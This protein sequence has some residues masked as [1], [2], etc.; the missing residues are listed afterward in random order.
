MNGGPSI[1]AVTPGERDKHDQKFDTLS[2]TMGYVSGEQARKFFLQSGLPSSVLAEI[3]SLADMNKDG[4]MDRL[5]FSIA[6]KLV[7]LKL[8][9]TPLPSALPTIMK[10]PPLPVLS[11][12]NPSSSMTNPAYGIGSLSNMSMMPGTNLSMLIPLSLATPG[13]SPLTPMTGLT[14]LVPMATG[15]S[16]L[17]ASTNTRPMGNVT[18]PNGTMG[19]LHPMPTGPLATGLPLSVSNY[20]SPLGMSSS[21]AGIYK[22]SSMLDLG[23]SSSA[24]SSPSV[25]SPMVAGPSDWAVPHASRLKYR[26]QFNGLDKQMTGHLTGQQVRGAMATTM[27]TQTQLASIW[28]LADV[29]KDGK[30]KAEEFILAMH[31]VDMA[32]T[33]LP[34]PL[35][36]P[37]ELVPPSQRGAVN[38]SSSSLYAA[39]TD[40]FDIEPPQK[41]K[42]NLSFED[43]FKANQERGNA[44]L[45]KRRLALQEAER[46]ELERRAQKE[47]EEREKRE[48]EAWEAEERRRKEE[49]RRLERQRELE[50]QKEEERQREIERKE[51][52]QRELE[53]QR[54]EEWE[55]RRR[56]ELQIKKQQEQDDI[57]R[58]KAKKRS[59]EM[60]L[61]AVGNKHRQISDRLRDI[62]NKKKLQRTELDL[63]SQ[64]KE[65]RQQDINSIHKQL[66]EFQRKLS[67]LTPEQKRL[68]EKLKNMTLNNLP[69]SSM[70]TMKV[71]VSEKKGTCMKLRDHLQTLEKETAA[72]LAEMDHYNKDMQYVGSEDSMLQAVF[73]LLACLRNLFYLLKELRESQRKQ[74][75]ALE[76]LRSVKEDKQR[77]LIRRKEQE[78]ERK[79]QEEE[80]RRREEEE[81]QR[82][83]K[84]EKE[85]QWQEKLK[86]DEEE[87]QRRLREEKE[88]KQREE[89]ERERQALIRAAKDQAER[90]F[91]AKEEAE[92]KRREEERRKREDEERKKKEEEERQRQVERQ[93]QEEERRKLEEERRK[94]EEERRKLEEERRKEEKRRKDEEE[95]KRLEAE[96]RDEECR[97]EREE[98][99]RR[100]KR[101][102]EAAVRDAE[103]R[104]K[105]D[106]E[107]RKRREE[108]DRRKRDEERRRLQQEQQ[109]EERRRREEERKKGEEERSRKKEEEERRKAEEERKR[110]EEASRQQQQPSVVGKLDIQEKLTNLLRGL[111]ERKGGQPRATHHRK[112]AALTSFKALFP[113][114]ARNNEE[115]SFNADDIIEVDETTEREEGWLYG[116]KLGKMG[117][118]PESYV[119][120]GTPSN[121]SNNTVASAAAA[122]AAVPTKVPLQSQ[123]SNVLEAAKAA[124]TKSAFTPTHSPNLAPLETQGQLVVGNLLA[125]A[126][127]SWTAKTDSHLNFNKD[128]VIQ[129]L[130]QQENWWLGELNS[131]RG[132]FPKTYVTLLGEEES[133]DLKSSPP[134]VSESSDGL[135][136]E[137]YLALY[138]YESPEPGDLTFKEGDMI[139]VSKRDGEWWSG[140]IG[141]R[142]GVFPSNYVKPKET[143]TSSISGKKKQEIGQVIKAHP[144]TGP[145]QLNLENGQ[146]VLVLGKNT[147]G[148]WLGELQARGKKRQKGWFP[149][150]HIKILGSNSGKSTPAPQP[151]CQVIAIYDYTAANGDEM[152]FSKSQLINVMD[153]SNP[154]WWKGEING[155]T[156]L[157]PTNYV[158]MTTADCDPSQQWCADLNS[159]DSMSP[160]EKKRQ[161]YIHELIQTEERYMEDLNIVLEVFQ[162]P[163]S[164]SGRVNDAEMSM[165]F[166][167]WKE[168][169]A[170]NTKLLKALRVRKKTGGDNMPVQMIGDI[171]A[172]ELSHMQPYIRFCSCQ[173]NGATLLQ[174][175]TDNEPDFKT[176][177]KKI[178]TDYRCKG[179]PLSSFLL[180]P[181]QRITRYPLHIKS[182]LES[183]AEGHAD[184][185]PLREALERAEELCQQV[186]EG[187]REKENSDRLEWIQT[188]VQCDGAAENLVFNSLTNCLGPRKLLHSGKMFKA[189][190]NKELWSFLFKDFLLL[191]YAAKQF[192]SSGPDKL[193]SN[194]NNAQLKMY[195]PPVLLNEVLVKLPDPSSD[196]PIFHISHIDRVYILRTDN[197]NERTAWVQKIKAA[198]EEFIDTEKRKREK[199]YQ[200]R[201]VKTSGIGRLLVTILEATELKAGKPSGK[202]NPYCEVTMGAQI[203]TSRTLNDTLN[204]KWNFNCQFHIR[205]IYQDVLCITVFERD[206]FSPDVFLGRTE[207]PVATIKK[208]LENKGPVTRRLLLHEVPTGEV[209]VRLDLQ[210]FSGK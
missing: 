148:W 200:A 198:S 116:S 172:A 91:R 11:L 6:M 62:H 187:V 155:V 179:M 161:G 32:K 18:L 93:R 130:E 132:W 15:L 83:I 65:S 199:A 192:T 158:K 50:R 84:M 9:G 29:D 131:E 111:E 13:L 89:E 165:I 58:L 28:T 21:P 36:L 194:K 141:D 142:T 86:M 34:L 69:V 117:W 40:D 96:R 188:H 77:E 196:E 146:L 54:K 87:R 16:P 162:R 59:L 189:K 103:E 105:H 70:S 115:L 128:D 175:R 207:V 45:E 154:D 55:R 193:F 51:A 137:E 7:K 136:P 205:D 176:F 80:S 4:K 5:E 145:E 204:P 171:L 190:S 110:K 127:C 185:D 95:R 129:V 120:R 126:L 30:L 152:S 20:S 107:E 138:T 170:C 82:R 123:L 27:L 75:V 66:E 43:R 90:E 78:E 42:S 100:S 209:W 208:E 39:L 76:K 203:F 68:K 125:Q 202:S 160:Q 22:A 114:T 109:E 98:E 181:M 71:S 47:R 53:R 178:A 186:N 38:G 166:V 104:K 169:L 159:L 121:T 201:S 48:R 197:I 3:W 163:M 94:L 108:E 73:C 191:T 35:I 31:L 92:R 147:T 26:Q 112:S 2:P 174:N 177:L 56:G 134:D 23:S 37:I 52:A 168:L 85:R 60:E 106:E 99:E 195:K 183:T 61:E 63:T 10:Q 140:S 173:I 19:I 33:G 49:E 133:S 206:Q 164:E 119:E 14:P 184:R 150:S 79:R 180:K 182:I 157:F 156:G 74:Q 149:S 210:L 102:A 144:S 97:R 167:N 64:R 151:V 101:A 72:K 113:F 12:H 57:I 81:A 44:E 124:G 8:Q 153:K 139:L 88:A 17:I 41:V 24:S 143:D 46:R 122:A 1:W 25:M 67:Q 118:F 135:Q